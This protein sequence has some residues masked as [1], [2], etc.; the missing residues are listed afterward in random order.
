MTRTTTSG[1]SRHQML[2]DLTWTDDLRL[3]G[4]KRDASFRRIVLG[5]VLR[6]EAVESDETRGR[7][8]GDLPKARR[9]V[10]GLLAKASMSRFTTPEV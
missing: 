8:S 4:E 2:S 10:C 6:G 9:V 7:I 3:N 1:I 5:K